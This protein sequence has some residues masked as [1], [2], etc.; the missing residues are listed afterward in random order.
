[1]SL[2][3]LHTSVPHLPTLIRLIRHLFH[4]S[5][6]MS[7]RINYFLYTQKKYVI[8]SIVCIYSK[9]TCYN[10]Y[11][12]VM[13]APISGLEIVLHIILLQG[14]SQTHR[15]LFHPIFFHFTVYHLR[16]N[17]CK[18]WELDLHFK[19]ESPGITNMYQLQFDIM[20]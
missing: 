2:G 14:K 4:A 19:M 5:W 13:Q 18:R 9:N 3:V 20:K 17:H 1:M 12:V 16:C 7:N 6:D 8:T 10:N 11:F 15:L